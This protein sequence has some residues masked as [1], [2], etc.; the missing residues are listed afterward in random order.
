MT[1]RYLVQVHYSVVVP[2]NGER[3]A[4]ELAELAAAESL[5]LL[6]EKYGSDVTLLDEYAPVAV[7]AAVMP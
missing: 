6:G 7:L 3:E 5:R 2:A 4:K 1:R